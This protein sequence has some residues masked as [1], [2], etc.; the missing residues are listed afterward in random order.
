MVITLHS[1]ILNELNTFQDVLY[2]GVDAAGRK[3]VLLQ[4]QRALIKAQELGDEKIEVMNNVQ[5][6]VENKSKQ[7]ETDYKNLG[8]YFENNL[9][10]DLKILKLTIC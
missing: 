5:D 7:L 1:V 4:I 8:M 2:R 6:M 10:F 3:R 9:N